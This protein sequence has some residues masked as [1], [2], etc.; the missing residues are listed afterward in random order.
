MR[1]LGPVLCVVWLAVSGVPTGAGAQPGTPSPDAV[2]RA[3]A[4]AETARRLYTEGDYAGAVAAYREAY[5]VAPAGALLYNIAYIYDRKLDLPDVAVE[6]YRRTLE[7]PDVDPELMRRATKRL[8]TLRQSRPA[9]ELPPAERPLSAQEIGGWVGV[10]AGAGIF[11]TGLVLGLVANDRHGDFES[12]RDLD[13]K[14]DLRD[15]GRTLAIAGDVL[16]GVGLAGAVAGTILL[17]TAD[18]GGPADSGVT[19]PTSWRFGVE[20]L[21]AGAVLSVGGAL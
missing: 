9:P 16:M 12:S 20:P 5:E 11:A 19:A 17:L 4:L 6:Y 15:E 3:E 8:E 14:R 2:P 10:G 1:R 13:D 18:G 21:P 7:S